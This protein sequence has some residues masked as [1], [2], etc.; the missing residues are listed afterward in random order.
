MDEEQ[1]ITLFFAR[2]EQAIEA[3]DAKYGK[4]FHSLSYH[5]VN[6]R[7]DADECVNDAYLGAWNAIPPAKPDSLLPY[8]A[9]IVRN[10]SL[11]CYWKK[12][13]A[14]RNSPY[15]LALQ[16]VEECLPDRKSAEEEVEARELARVIACFSDSCRDIAGL[17]GLSEKNISVRLTRIR[18]KLKQYLAEREAF[19]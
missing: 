14:K 10:I 15:T 19:L 13:A 17:V 6:D 7:Q 11:K 4:L 8:M 9:R 2:S 18:R 12:G 1:I 16:E 3:L 5:I